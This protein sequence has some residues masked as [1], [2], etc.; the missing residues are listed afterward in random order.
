MAQE[1]A[2]KAAFNAA[3]AVSETEGWMFGKIGEQAPAKKA[4]AAW[5]GKAVE[6]VDFAL[7]HRTAPA[8]ALWIRGGA[9][10][11]H[12]GKKAFADL[13]RLARLA[14]ETWQRVLL[15]VSDAIAADEAEVEAVRKAA[16]E[17]TRR[18]AVAADRARAG[19]EPGAEVFEGTILEEHPDPL[20][21]SD[22]A[23]GR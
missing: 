21:P 8:E 17:K 4:V 9:L 20:A 14:F 5:Q 15:S 13:P 1:K 18:D 23:R 7:E 16:E 10:G 3:L 12:D 11:F 22:I 19:R 2:V 6:F